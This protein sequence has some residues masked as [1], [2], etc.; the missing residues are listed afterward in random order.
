MLR[1][2]AGLLWLLLLSKAAAGVELRGVVAGEELQ[3]MLRAAVLRA[4]GEREGLEPTLGSP[5]HATEGQAARYKM[6]GRA[7][8][9]RL[10]SETTDLHSHT[11]LHNNTQHK[12]AHKT[13]AHHYED[14]K[15]K[16]VHKHIHTHDHYHDHSHHHRHA[17]DHQHLQDHKHAHDHKHKYA[18]G[19][20]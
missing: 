3:K 7:G 18:K 20:D 17:A 19:G 1:Q 14:H 5:G 8:F 11:H 10:A 9:Q 12:H 4:M 16:A 15:H 2:A 6:E 13:D